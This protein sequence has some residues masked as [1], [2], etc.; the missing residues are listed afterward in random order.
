MSHYENYQTWPEPV[1][2][3]V[4][5][6]RKDLNDAFKEKNGPDGGPDCGQ[7]I[8]IT[9]SFMEFGGW[10]PDDKPCQGKEHVIDKVSG[11]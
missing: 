5:C 7:W 9:D 2:I 8:F 10:E 6:L 1:Y 3:C 11:R 4:V